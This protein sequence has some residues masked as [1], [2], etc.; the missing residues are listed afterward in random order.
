LRGLYDCPGN[1][2]PRQY[3]GF[4]NPA[5]ALFEHPS[6]V[7]VTHFLPVDYKTPGMRLKRLERLLN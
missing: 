4:E 1:P 3:T 6:Q 7:R 2:K 5:M